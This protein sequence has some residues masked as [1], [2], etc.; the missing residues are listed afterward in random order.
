LLVKPTYFNQMA[1]IIQA[2]AINLSAPSTASVCPSAPAGFTITTVVGDIDIEYTA[3][4]G[5]N[6]AGAEA[7]INLRQGKAGGNYRG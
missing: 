2:D 3:D 4:L 1:I 5:V 6:K 7:S